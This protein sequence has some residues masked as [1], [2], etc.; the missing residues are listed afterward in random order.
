L[1]VTEVRPPKKNGDFDV[2]G[3]IIK[4]LKRTAGGL[5]SFPSVFCFV[6]NAEATIR[7]SL[8]DKGY[9]K[10]I[11]GLPAK[12]ILRHRHTRMYYRY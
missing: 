8:I 3:I 11:I 6:E 7:Q 4:S 5:S 10:G 1:T 12:P 2:A 9:I